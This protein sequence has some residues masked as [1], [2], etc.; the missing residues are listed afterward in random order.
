MEEQEAVRLCQ[1]GDRDA[2]R[3]LVERYQSVLFGTAFL[4]TRDQAVT[5]ELVQDALL[6]AWKGIGGF[7]G[8]GPVKPW[9]VRILV[10]RVV[11]HQRRRSLPVVPIAEATEPPAPD[12]TAQEA[13]AKDSVRR[14]LAELSEEQRQVVMLRYFSELTVPEIADVLDMPEG[15]VK[16]R[17]SRSLTELRKVIG[18]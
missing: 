8:D 2:F 6:S 18:E 11:S 15:T 7:R 1:D 4:M 10:N 5:E 17:L 9:L 16:S 13:E 12:R 3:V 14:G